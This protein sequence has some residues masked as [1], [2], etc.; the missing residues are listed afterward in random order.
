MQAY[1]GY[2]ENGRVI[3]LGNLPDGRRVIITV[4]DEAVENPRAEQQGKALQVF[5]KGLQACTPL[6]PEFDDILEK[7]VNITR[8]LAL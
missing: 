3:P 5:Q 4:L 6:P 2:T 1:S 7:R 8:E